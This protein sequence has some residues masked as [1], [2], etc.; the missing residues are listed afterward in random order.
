MLV[1]GHLRADTTPDMEVPVLVLDLNEEESDKLLAT[2]DPLSAMAQP[3]TDALLAL[4]ADMDFTD[5]AVMDML[6]ALA[7]GEVTP[8]PVLGQEFDESIADNIA[9][10]RCTECG[11]EHHKET[12]LS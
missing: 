3:D 5:K 1:D 12:K 7:N 11:N 6:E 2:L 10:C 8:L 4:I 9:L